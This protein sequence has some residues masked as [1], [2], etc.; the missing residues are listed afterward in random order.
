VAAGVLAT[1]GTANIRSS[2]PLIDQFYNDGLEK[3]SARFAMEARLA[4]TKAPNTPVQPDLSRYDN[5]INITVAERVPIDPFMQWERRDG[6][7]RIPGVRRIELTYRYSTNADS[8]IVQ[9]IKT[10]AGA[11][12]QAD[13]F[14][15]PPV[16]RLKWIVPPASVPLP[17]VSTLPYTYMDEITRAGPVVTVLIGQASSPV[18]TQTFS[19]IRLRHVPRMLLVYVKRDVATHALGD[20]TEKHMEITNMTLNYSTA[21]GSLISASSPELFAMYVKNSPV[22][23]TRFFDYEKWRRRY[24][25]VA[26]R[27][28]DHGIQYVEAGGVILDLSLSLV[29]H[30][31]YPAVG[32]DLQYGADANVPY[33]MHLVAF[34]N[35]G[36]TMSE[37]DSLIGPL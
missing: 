24:C 29:S 23:S 32:R 16:L 12:V 4:P 34:Y 26:L 17:L 11:D 2:T 3:R 15:T 36:L 7:K 6:H 19:N 8:L 31:N 35:Y 20:P 9:G 28:E 27:P 25:T 37:T 5:E 22:S 18:V 14:T 1:N 13:W 33:V 30:W 10:G 21:K